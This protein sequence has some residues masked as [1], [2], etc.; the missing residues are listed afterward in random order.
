MD[1][2]ANGSFKRKTRD[3]ISSTGYIVH[4][5]EAAL[6]A[7]YNTASFEQGALLAGKQPGNL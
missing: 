4:S 7:L 1:A 2:I 6:W 3:Q 5:M